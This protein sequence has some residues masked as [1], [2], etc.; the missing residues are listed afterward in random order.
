MVWDFS[1]MLKIIKREIK[2][3][4]SFISQRKYSKS[5]GTYELL[6]HI[7]DIIYYSAYEHWKKKKR[8]YGNNGNNSKKSRGLY[9]QF[10][11]IKT[12]QADV[13]PQD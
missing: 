2:E 6:E 3:F 13:S 9:H 11:Y 4:R 8:D 7:K 12:V 1:F 5:V 10:W